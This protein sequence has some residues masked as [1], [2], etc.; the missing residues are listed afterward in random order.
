MRPQTRIIAFLVATFALSSVFYARIIA[1]GKMHALPVFALMWS[2]GV[3]AI[4]VRLATARNLRG[5]GWTWGATRW[6]IASY[7]IPLAAASVVYGAAWL[8]GIGGLDVSALTIRTMAKQMSPGASL[9]FLATIGFVVSAFLFA[10]GE[11]IGWRGF[12]VPELA[13]VTTFTRTA[14]IS[15]VVWAVY[16]FP[17]IL[18][19]D[20]NSPAPKWFGITMFSW[21]V[22]AMSFVLAWIRLKSGSL[23]TSAVFHGSHNLFVQEVFDR[24]TVNRGW[25]P[26]LTTEFGVGLAIAYT[27][28]AIWL[29]R[30]SS[31]PG[32]SHDEAAPVDSHPRNGGVGQRDAGRAIVEAVDGRPHG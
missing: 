23:W 31:A 11:E 13:R 24:V 28:V 12:L 21:G 25:T 2:P 26:Y 3:A 6:Q 20:Y 22:L 9:V 8:T 15:G 30:V 4:I 19:A 16:H 5:A 10:L 18:F 7:L 32:G 27:L 1:D 14:L 17:I 29:Y